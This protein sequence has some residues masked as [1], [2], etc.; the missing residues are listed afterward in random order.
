[1]TWHLFSTTRLITPVVIKD[2]LLDYFGLH[3]IEVVDMRMTSLTQSATMVYVTIK[4]TA[5]AI[6]SDRVT[7]LM[8][9]S[10]SSKILDDAMTRAAVME[11]GVE[12]AVKAPSIMVIEAFVEM[13]LAVRI[14]HIE[15]RMVCHATVP[16][17]V[18]I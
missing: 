9:T 15:V 16:V 12:A 3:K 7:R 17:Q 2:H 8:I 18:P 10:T 14:R 4:A 11:P 5:T 1:M 13:A 6:S